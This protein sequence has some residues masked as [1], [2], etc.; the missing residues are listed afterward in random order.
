MFTINYSEQPNGIDDITNEIGIYR[1]TNDINGRMYIGQSVRMRER[2]L[3]HFSN[4]R[5][6]AHQNQILQKDFNKYGVK[7]FTVDVLEFCEEY[8]LDEREIYYNNKYNTYYFDENSNGYNLYLCGKKGKIT[9]GMERFRISSDAHKFESIP[10]YQIDLQGNIVK[11]WECGAREASKV[12]K[13]NQACIWHC[14]NKI[15]KTYKKSIWI[16]KEEYDT[17]GIPDISIYYNSKNTDRNVYCYDFKTGEYIKTYK[18]TR[19]TIA[20]G[21]DD[22]QVCKVL[23]GKNRQSKGFVFSLEK[24]NNYYS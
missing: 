21:F 19:A 8:K 14:V 4:L 10:I 24:K 18:N 3:C 15:R 5:R 23:K 13:I 12:L 7:N 16:S 1:I 20:D 6:N 22:S 2:V 9:K 11:L 17:I